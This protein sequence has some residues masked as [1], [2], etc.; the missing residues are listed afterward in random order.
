MFRRGTGA[1]AVH[2]DTECD[3]RL[4]RVILNLP[5]EGCV[6]NRLYNDAL[7]TRAPRMIV[8]YSLW[9]II[10]LGIF[11][12]LSGCSTETA[13]ATYLDPVAYCAAVD[14][15]DHPDPR[16]IGP[17][18]P[19]W[20]EFSLGKRMKMQVATSESALSPVAWRCAGGAIM[21][22]SIGLGMPC[23]QKPSMSRVPARAAIEFCRAFP[24]I[25]RPLPN[26]GSGLSAYQ[27]VCRH[28]WPQLIGFQPDLDG[29][30]YLDRYWFEIPPD[31]ALSASVRRALTPRS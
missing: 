26:L 24:D 1:F 16:Y 23:E 18:V 7:A 21:A 9:V 10:G 28:G 22:C 11:A 29:A 6:G 17:A 15:I 31:D 14:T 12:A 19:E 5:N 20:I 30:G 13:T 3:C 27:W 4:N 25:D 2:Q 8:R